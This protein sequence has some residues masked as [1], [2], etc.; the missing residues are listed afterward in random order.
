MIC[1]RNPNIVRLDSKG[2]I[3]IPNHLR[4]QINSEE[5]T[6]FIFINDGDG[7]EDIRIVPLLKEKTAEIRLLLGD[8]VN[9]LTSIAEVFAHNNISIIMSEGKTHRKYTQWEFIIDTTRFQGNLDEL[10]NHLMEGN[11]IKKIEIIR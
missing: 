10:K 8:G 5:G 6:E 2:R 1:L 9:G 11:G 7:G 4:Q 3:L